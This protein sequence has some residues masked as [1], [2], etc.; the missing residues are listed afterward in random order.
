MNLKQYKNELIVLFTFLLMIGA[1]F[2]KQHNIK[3]ATDNSKKTEQS[4]ANIKELIDL[5]STWSDKQITKKVDRLKRVVSSHKVTFK[6]N[7]K[8]A[9][10]YFK[11]LQPKELDRVVN[12]ILNLAVVI[13]QLEIKKSGTTYSVEFKCKW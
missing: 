7:G 13:K 5:K 2:Y 11:N 9:T 1:F 6:R 4:L 3:N 8:K 10:I 12:K